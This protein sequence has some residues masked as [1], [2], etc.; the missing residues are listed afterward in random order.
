M[1]AFFYP[2]MCGL[3]SVRPAMHVCQGE[4]GGEGGEL[5]RGPCWVGRSALML[6]TSNGW[7]A[8]DAS[9]SPP[10]HERASPVPVT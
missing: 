9:I 1:L 10:S 4:L 8:L 7:V 3:L 6:I 2:D 5:A